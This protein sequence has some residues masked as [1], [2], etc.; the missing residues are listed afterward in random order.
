MY[1]HL[2]E[3]AVEF[4]DLVI[5]ASALF[6]VFEAPLGVKIRALPGTS[7]VQIRNMSTKTCDSAEKELNRRINEPSFGPQY[8]SMTLDL[9]KAIDDYFSVSEV[10]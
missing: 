10:L 5:Y 6:E 9:K 8:Q 7:S 1:P 2:K 3:R 4:G